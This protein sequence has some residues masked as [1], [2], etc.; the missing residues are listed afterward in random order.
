MLAQFTKGSNDRPYGQ[1]LPV[2]YDR[3]TKTWAPPA[4]LTYEPDDTHGDR[5]HHV[6]QHLIPNVEKRTHSVFNVPESK[7]L[8][9]IDEAWRRESLAV[10]IKQ[11]KNSFAYDIQMDRVVGTKDE[12][13]IRVVIEGKGSGNVIT[14]FPLK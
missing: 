14:S 13:T 6:M 8:T 2:T 10:V 7:V 3:Q 5:I 1:E 12:K 4:G 9:L 11:P